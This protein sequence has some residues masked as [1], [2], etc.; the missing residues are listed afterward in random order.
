MTKRETM[1]MLVLSSVVVVVVAV[2]Q[3]QERSFTNQPMMIMVSY[4]KE[5]RDI[6]I[7]TVHNTER[8]TASPM[9]PN[10][11]ITSFSSRWTDL[12]WEDLLGCVDFTF[13][14]GALISDDEAADVA[15]KVSR[16]IEGFTHLTNILFG[17]LEPLA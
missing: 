9:H 13:A 16:F 2:H 8:P 1:C 14:H 7:F 4:S 6:A 15:N 17:Q 5:R 11:M 12:V 3:R 10:N